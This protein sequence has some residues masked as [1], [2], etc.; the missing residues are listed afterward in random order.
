[1]GRLLE[2]RKFNFSFEG[3]GNWDQEGQVAFKVPVSRDSGP[4]GVEAGPGCWG[5]RLPAG[6]TSQGPQALSWP[7]WG[8]SIPHIL[9][10][11]GCEE[12]E[13]K[14]SEQMSKGRP[15]GR[16]HLTQ[17]RRVCSPSCMSVSLSRSPGKTLRWLSPLSETQCPRITPSRGIWSGNLFLNLP[18]HQA[19]SFSLREAE[20]R[21]KRLNL[22]EPQLLRL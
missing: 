11:C 15:G 16:Q 22:S 4:G 19:A 6:P 17:E 21:S 13:A 12:L 7:P 8:H 1:M 10:C 2:T 5:L 3:Q 14:A 9:L 18:D 20:T